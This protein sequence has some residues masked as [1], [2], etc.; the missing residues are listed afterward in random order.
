M[1]V[2]TVHRSG[3]GHYVRRPRRRKALGAEARVM[4]SA[5][6][7][8]NSLTLGVPLSPTLRRNRW[9]CGKPLR[10]CHQSDDT[11]IPAWRHRSE[12][13]V[14]YTGRRHRAGRSLVTSHCGFSDRRSSVADQHRS[15]RLRLS[16]HTSVRSSRFTHRQPEAEKVW[17]KLIRPAFRYQRGVTSIGFVLSF[18]DPCKGTSF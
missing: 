14:R 6:G 18:G 11:R 7:F 13:S 17:S 2:T 5:H 12:C 3:S 4:M 9:R 1:N 16:T 15:C 8:S 10:Y